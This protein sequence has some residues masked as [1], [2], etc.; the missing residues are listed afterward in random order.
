MRAALG[1][2][3][4][5]AGTAI[6]HDGA[7]RASEVLFGR[8]FDTATSYC[9]TAPAPDC[10]G[11]LWPIV[12]HNRDGVLAIGEVEAVF[13]SA[14]SWAGRPTG[15][16][17]AIERNVAVVSLMVLRYAGLRTV[18]GNFDADGNGVLTRAEVFGD[19]R[20]DG[21]PFAKLVADKDAVDWHA[22]AGKFGK[23]G[24]LIRDIL[25]PARAPKTR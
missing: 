17:N 3:L 14:H 10:V 2:C 8:F 6:A 21:R 11:R 5:I 1:I 22:F 20:M 7:A 15:S 9:R 24:V 18:F 16:P 13:R 12:D 4:A 23:A 19:F 25:P